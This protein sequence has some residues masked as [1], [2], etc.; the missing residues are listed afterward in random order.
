M[1]DNRQYN[2]H[3][4]TIIGPLTSR[5]SVFCGIQN[6]WGTIARVR[7]RQHGNI[8]LI[9]RLRLGNEAAHTNGN[10]R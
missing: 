4:R 2:E 5:L 3:Q 9:L 7:R 8:F 1:Y 10:R 6:T